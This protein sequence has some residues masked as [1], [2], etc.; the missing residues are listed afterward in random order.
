M[1]L[2]MDIYHDIILTNKLREQSL[3]ALETIFGWVV[4][5]CIP[6]NCRINAL[7]SLHVD[8]TSDVDLRRFWELE[9]LPTA[10]TSTTEE[11]ACEKHFVDTTT[12]QT[13][14]RFVVKIPFKNGS[15][16]NLDFTFDIARKR[17]L[18]VERR[19]RH[20]AV[21]RDAYHDFINEFLD[22]KHLEKILPN[23]V[24]KP[25]GTYCYLPHHIVRKD[26]ST[27]TKYRLVFDG[28]ACN[29]DK[30]S[31]NTSIL[32]GA[33]L[34]DDLLQILVRFRWHQLHFLQILQK[35]TDKS[36]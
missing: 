29:S 8:R 34:Q 35:C 13:D 11:L 28:S 18:S 20:D 19:F 4:S 12:R 17:L 30:V 5:G 32:V 24:A 16:P 21:V 15:P 3:V 1:I 27:T 9:E 31:L 10:P 14:G 2:G 36:H 33:K 7:H 23:E 22:L 26:S 6:D 25:S